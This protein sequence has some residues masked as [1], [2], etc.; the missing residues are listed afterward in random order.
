MSED[1]AKSYLK[2]LIRKRNICIIAGAGISIYSGLPLWNELKDIVHDDFSDT[3][4]FQEFFEKEPAELIWELNMIIPN[5]KNKYKS[6]LKTIFKEAEPSDTHLELLKLRPQLIVT[7]NID[8]LLSKAADKLN[9]SETIIRNTDSFQSIYENKGDRIAITHVHGR[10]D[11]RFEDWILDIND[12]EK[13]NRSKNEDNTFSMYIEEL[14]HQIDQMPILFIGFSMSDNIFL[15]NLFQNRNSNSLPIFV[16][17]FK[18]QLSLLEKRIK[19]MFEITPICVQ[20][21]AKPHNQIIKILKDLNPYYPTTK[22]ND[23][24][25]KSEVSLDIKYLKELS[26][27]EEKYHSSKIPSFLE[28]YNWGWWIFSSWFHR[29]K[30]KKKNILITKIYDVLVFNTVIQH[31]YETRQTIFGNKMPGKLQT[32]KPHDISIWDVNFQVPNHLSS[33]SEE[34]FLGI[35]YNITCDLCNGTGFVPCTCIKSVADEKPL[36]YK[37]DLSNCELC[38]GTHQIS[39]NKCYGEGCFVA[40]KGL[41]RNL[42][43]SQ[44]IGS[45]LTIP[46]NTN[47]RIIK[48]ELPI[49]SKI[50]YERWSRDPYLQMK[51]LKNTTFKL[52]KIQ[53]VFS[54]E[55]NNKYMEY[56]KGVL[57]WIPTEIN[58]YHKEKM[59]RHHLFSNVSFLIQII[60]VVH[61]DYKFFGWVWEHNYKAIVG[62]WDDGYCQVLNSYKK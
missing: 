41:R 28:N 23:I 22:E 3:S 40:E 57:K 55:I 21:T 17:C 7:T 45:P 14:R 5:F 42:N 49:L 39:C 37:E 60:R 44:P 43:F 20:R 56:I 32:H 59:E 30:P 25:P 1:I 51:I 34:K 19:D 54:T 10:V 12:Y 18:D 15:E 6:E 38:N 26:I 29:G 13:Y 16:I 2:E 4:Q 35:G 58:N 62:I 36:P 47:G 33:N 50:K 61:I 8:P 48:E 46:I 11:Q 53:T 24:I 52:G 31:Q 9:I 27:L